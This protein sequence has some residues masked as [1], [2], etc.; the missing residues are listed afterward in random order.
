MEL[1]PRHFKAL[2]NGRQA[3]M[4]RLNDIMART[5]RRQQPLEQRLPDGQGTSP[6]GRRQPSLPVHRP[7]PEQTA[8]MGQNPHASQSYNQHNLPPRTRDEQGHPI[9]PTGYTRQ[10]PQTH[11]LD[12]SAGNLPSR[13][14][15]A[16]EMPLRNGSFPA[17]AQPFQH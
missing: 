6:Q 8:R 9:P 16:R 1:Y 2:G 10:R 17:D 12:R 14:R 3:I 11:D 15:P 7:L 13:M 4:E 5:T